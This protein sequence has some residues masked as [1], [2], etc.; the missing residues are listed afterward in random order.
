MVGYAAAAFEH[1]DDFSFI[2]GNG[3]FVERAGCAAED[4][5][6]CQPTER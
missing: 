6:Q 1:A 5:A 2:V 4:D 3:E